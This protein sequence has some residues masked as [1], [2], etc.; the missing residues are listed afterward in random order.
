[1]TAASTFLLPGPRILPGW[2]RDLAA[3]RPRRLWLC[4][5]LLHR[6]DAPVTVARVAT[7]DPLRLG[8]LRH[9]AAPGAVPPESLHLA[10]ALLHRLL[11]ELAADG[12]IEKTGCQPT[13][14]GRHA[15]RDGAYEA[16]AEERRDFH[17]VDNAGLGRPAYFLHLN[18]SLG[19]PAPTLER[20]SFDAALLRDCV[21]RPP[22]WKA[23]HQ[24]PADVLAVADAGPGTPP[25]LPA[26]RCVIAD[27]PE[28]ALLVLAL[29]STE[30]GEVLHGFTV[31][32]EGWSLFRDAPL[33][34]L[35]ADWA[36]VFPELAAEPTPDDWRRAW[37]AWSQP[38]G[39]S[40][41]DAEACVLE[42]DS[43]RLRVRVPRPVLEKL[44]AAK[45]DPLKHEGGVLVGEVR[46]RRIVPLEVGAE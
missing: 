12:L 11:R 4:P 20:W 43:D 14:A 27:H 13:D 1:M 31:R 21:R 16:R 6:L 35:T 44:R 39:I 30:G 5:L 26:W 46:A 32:T 7:L 24:F 37:L 34:T 19:G 45:G 2:W 33:L 15:A 18:R 42:V 29:T 28:Q 25:G 40:A 41:T 22:E 8:L 9:L 23:R 17:F 3:L 10:P 38:R 36:E